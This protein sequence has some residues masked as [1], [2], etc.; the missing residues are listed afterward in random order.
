[1]KKSKP[2][3]VYRF[4]EDTTPESVKEFKKMIAELKKPGTICVEMIA[5][6]QRFTVT[7]GERNGEECLFLLDQAQAQRW[8]KRAFS[9][10][11]V[12]PPFA[13]MSTEPHS[14]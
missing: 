6:G 7:I 3:S 10:Q 13:I 5:Y 12:D 14:D 11:P 1:M 8:M 9:H 4:S 2:I